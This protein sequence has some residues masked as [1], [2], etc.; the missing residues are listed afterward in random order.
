MTLNQIVDECFSRA[1]EQGLEIKAWAAKSDLCWQN[2]HRI[3]H[4][5]T[6]NPYWRTVEK[7]S[8]AVGLS[9]QVVT[10]VK[11]RRKSA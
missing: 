2:I 10:A 7:M 9:I 1:D 4:G 11:W 3:A 6:K 5:V 8:R